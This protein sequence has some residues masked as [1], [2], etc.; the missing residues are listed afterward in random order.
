[1]SWS[2]TNPK[3]ILLHADNLTLKVINVENGSIEE[4][5]ITGVTAARWHPRQAGFVLVGTL[6]GR[7]LLYNFEKKKPDIEYNAM[8][9]IDHEQDLGVD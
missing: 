4:V 7:V 6:E 2:P 9:K 5:N 3:L 8:E 1:V